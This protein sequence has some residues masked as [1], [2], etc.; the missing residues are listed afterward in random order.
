MKETKKICKKYLSVLLIAVIFVSIFSTV[1]VKA[2]NTLEENL[3]NSNYE[4]LFNDGEYQISTVTELDTLETSVNADQLAFKLSF[5]GKEISARGNLYKL[6]GAALYSN[7]IVADITESSCTILFSSLSRGQLIV[8]DHKTPEESIFNGKMM[9]TC[10]VRWDDTKEIF[11][12]KTL[13]DNENSIKAGNSLDNIKAIDLDNPIF[14]KLMLDG[15][16]Y[17]IYIKENRDS[18]GDVNSVTLSLSE[19]LNEIQQPYATSANP[20]DLTKIDVLKLYG[21]YDFLDETNKD[22]KEALLI[23]DVKDDDERTIHFGIC[24]LKLVDNQYLGFIAL[25]D[26]TFTLSSS[27]AT[28]KKVEFKVLRKYNY[29][30]QKKPGAVLK[31]SD[32]TVCDPDSSYVITQN[33][34]MGVRISGDNASEYFEVVKFSKTAGGGKFTSAES[35]GKSIIKSI[36]GALHPVI[37]GVIAVTD[38]FAEGLEVIDDWTF[39]NPQFK[40]KNENSLYRKAIAMTLPAQLYKQNSELFLYTELV[41]LK[42]NSSSSIGYEYTVQIVGSRNATKP[43]EIKVVG[44][45]SS[46]TIK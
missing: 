2:E 34:G 45:H 3:D 18:L 16:W 4:D 12:I 24:D 10:V 8:Y 40:F 44:F 35:L 28:S 21:V 9:L 29:F 14:E 17:S 26:V 27:S 25:H 37:G 46:K 5:D 19:L 23:A 1:N 7:A 11:I 15:D 20:E 36:A 43:N 41:N 13:L 42:T 32:I 31:E 30:I 38:I 33:P 6:Q 39:N 22:F